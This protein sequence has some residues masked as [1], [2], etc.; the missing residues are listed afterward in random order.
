M[1]MSHIPLFYFTEEGTEAQRLSPEPEDAAGRRALGRTPLQ[2][3]HTY[4]GISQ[5]NRRLPL[6]KP[7]E[8]V[9]GPGRATLSVT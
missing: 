1:H 3:F 6:P 8:V 9:P 5:S 4:G 7:E 2:V